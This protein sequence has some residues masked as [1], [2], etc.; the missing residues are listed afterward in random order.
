MKYATVALL[1]SIVIIG[2]TLDIYIFIKSC[3]LVGNE[4]RESEQEV[5][6]AR[7]KWDEALSRLLKDCY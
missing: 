3:G 2:F 4:I 6:D 5:E 1:E 7:K